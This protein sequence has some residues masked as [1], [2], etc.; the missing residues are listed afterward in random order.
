MSSMCTSC[1]AKTHSKQH[2]WADMGEE[3]D[4]WVSSDVWKKT[5]GQVDVAKKCEAA[6]ANWFSTKS[7]NDMSSKMLT[8]TW[9]DQSISSSSSSCSTT[10]VSSLFKLSSPIIYCKLC[11]GEFEFTTKMQIDY[12][13][14]GWQFPKI[15]KACSEKRFQENS[16]NY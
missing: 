12:K 16:W 8:Q 4:E 6:V 2:C 5:T 15:C 1:G 7:K 10:S 11:D 13:K 9:S 3:K 14:R